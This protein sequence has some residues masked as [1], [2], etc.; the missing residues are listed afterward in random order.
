MFERIINCEKSGQVFIFSDQWNTEVGKVK[1]LKYKI[2]PGKKVLPHM[3]PGARQ[4]FKVLSG[5][6]MIR[7]GFNKRKVLAGE[8]VRTEVSGLHSQW[9]NTSSFVEVLEGYEP[10]IDIEPFF[11][12]LPHAES[13]NSF[14]KFVV[15]LS[16]FSYVVTSKSLLVRSMISAL[17]K[18]GNICGHRYWYLKHIKHLKCPDFQKHHKGVL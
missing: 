8:E 14:F 16:D 17:G 10:A 4:T 12:V 7:S 1:Q 9:N 3:H 13:S 2:A 5:E 18:L 15:F 6:L 11:T